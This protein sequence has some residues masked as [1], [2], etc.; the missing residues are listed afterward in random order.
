MKRRKRRNMLKGGRGR[1]AQPF[2]NLPENYG[3]TTI[4]NIK[5]G[6]GQFGQCG[7]AGKKKGG[8]LGKADDRQPTPHR[9]QIPAALVE[10]LE[11][12]SEASFPQNLPE[13]VVLDVPAFAS[14]L[15]AA[16]NTQK[17]DPFE[18]LRS[19]P[20]RIRNAAEVEEALARQYWGY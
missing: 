12:L 3:N 9:P 18:I 2:L 17:A 19:L 1:Q 10:T 6:N 13:A 16:A 15:I 20:F 7:N 14:V 4:R 8:R 5:H 11:K